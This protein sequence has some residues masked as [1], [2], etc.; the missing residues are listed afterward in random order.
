MLTTCDDA[1]EMAHLLNSA[2]V[3]IHI[4]DIEGCGRSLC[5]SCKQGIALRIGTFPAN[6]LSVGK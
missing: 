3:N 4:A 2:N 1:E 5:H 6:E